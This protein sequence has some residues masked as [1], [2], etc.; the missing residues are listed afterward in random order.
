MPYVLEAPPAGLAERFADLSHVSALVLLKVRVL[1]GLR[2]IQKTR[3]ALSGTVPAE[4]IVYLIRAQLVSSGG[5]SSSTLPKRSDILLA[6]PEAG[7]W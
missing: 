5:G 3:V 2:I 4:K 6:S 1:L 7:V